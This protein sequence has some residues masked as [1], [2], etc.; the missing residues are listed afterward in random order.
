MDFDKLYNKFREQ[1]NNNNTI[2]LIYKNYKTQEKISKVVKYY[3]KELEIFKSQKFQL[4]AVLNPQLVNT[5]KTTAKEGKIINTI[6]KMF[7]I[8]TLKILTLKGKLP[9]ILKQDRG[10]RSANLRP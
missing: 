6:I 5:N 2:K 9:A 8:L 3:S 1:D 7:E 10:N 4:S